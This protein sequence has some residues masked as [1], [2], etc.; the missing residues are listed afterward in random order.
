MTNGWRWHCM[1]Y[2]VGLLIAHFSNGPNDPNDPNGCRLQLKSKFQR[3]VVVANS[4]MEEYFQKQKK[5][6]E[7][8]RSN[9]F[10]PA[11]WPQSSW[12][13]DGA[14]SMKL[15]HFFPSEYSRRWIIASGI[16]QKPKHKRRTVS[17]EPINTDHFKPTAMAMH[18]DFRIVKL[19]I[20]VAVWRMCVCVWLCAGVCG[21]VWR[22]KIP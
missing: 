11:G 5:R 21:A 8:N 20:G 18:Y 14:D 10:I 17:R 12:I 1:D 9:D 6:Y 16:F 3:W 7:I 15:I 13:F 2:A 22:E 4:P 19:L